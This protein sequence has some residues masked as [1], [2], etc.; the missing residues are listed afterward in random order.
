MH[1]I[2][3]SLIRGSYII[4]HQLIDDDP[5]SSITPYNLYDK[6]LKFEKIEP[7]PRI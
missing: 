3:V 1:A 7:I 5:G 2:E 4:N 6:G